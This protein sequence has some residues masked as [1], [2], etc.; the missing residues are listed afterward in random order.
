MI[1]CFV[2]LYISFIF[3]RIIFILINYFVKLFTRNYWISFA[4]KN[5]PFVKNKIEKERKELETKFTK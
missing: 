3:F 2:T 1:F 4:A 5:I